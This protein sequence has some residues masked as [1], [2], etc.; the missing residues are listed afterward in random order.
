[1]RHARGLAAAFGVFGLW[2]GAWAA[3]LPAVK[4]GTGAT[5]ATL[6]LAL[7]AVSLVALPAMI[8][9]GRVADRLAGRLV[10]PTLLAFAVTGALPGFAGDIP[11]L[12]LLLALVGAATGALDVAVN[13]AAAQLESH[14]GVRVMDGLHAFFSIGVL[15]GGVAGGLARRAGASPREILLAA[16]AAAGAA[17]IANRHGEPSR[18]PA[19]HGGPSLV[20]RLLGV[21]VILGI[22][23]VVESGLEQWSSVYLEDSL[24]S[25][26]AISGLG[27]GLFAAAMATG[28]LLAQRTSRGTAA[29]RIALAGV[30]AASGIGI[31]VATHKPAVALVGLVTAGGGLALSAPT[32]FGEAGRLAGP[33]RRGAGV[34]T[35]AVLSYTGFLVGPPL[36]G[37]VAGAT[38]VR[39]GFVMLGGAAVLLAVAARRLRRRPESKA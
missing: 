11:T 26:P 8:L 25:S 27:P 1:V 2:W 23:F 28:R 15:C 10:A 24:G 22:A 6:G 31:A 38:S 21:G 5:P 33:G 7:L 18:Q 35:V 13:A 32:L 36:F 9:V 14:R 29:T 4:R 20:R 3:C 17:A 16:A 19:A 30:A 34:S 12:A 39:G 37:A